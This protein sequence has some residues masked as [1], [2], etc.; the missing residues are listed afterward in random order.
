[1]GELTPIRQLP[2]QQAGNLRPLTIG[3]QMEHLA[4]EVRIDVGAW[5]EKWPEAIFGLIITR[6]GERT[7]YPA[8]ITVQGNMISWMVSRYDTERAGM[9]GRMVLIAM[10]GDQE[11]A[12][13]TASITI[14][15]RGSGP[16][17]PD[18]PLPEPPWVDSV[19]D[20]AEGAANRAKDAAERAE[21]AWHFGPE[22]AGML[23][24]IAADGTPVPL[25]LGSGLEIK[26][27]MLM[28]TG[29]IAPPD[30]PPAQDIYFGADDEGHIILHGVSFADQGEG[31]IQV[32]NADFTDL[33]GGAIKIG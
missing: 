5:Q 4:T 20:R 29:Q 21:K 26:D 16:I 10:Q 14:L 27:G 11:V 2:T 13:N 17:D 32:Q 8:D 7:S 33:G 6:P 30:E 31:R 12:S 24:Y 25:Q 9:Y 28:I 15:E 23:L 18:T 19:V 3:Y 22:N 1:M